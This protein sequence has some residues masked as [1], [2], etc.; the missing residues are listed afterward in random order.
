MPLGSTANYSTSTQPSPI[1]ESDILHSLL[2]NRTPE[3]TKQERADWLGW[4]SHFV[5]G[6]VMGTIAGC[7]C[8]PGKFQPTFV[9]ATEFPI[10]LSGLALLGGAIA[11]F[12]GDELWIGATYRVILP[13]PP[14]HSRRSRLTSLG[15]AIA[16]SLL[17]TIAL[18]RLVN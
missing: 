15:V 16:G 9:S 13:M 14:K 17:V 18:H 8:L 12:Y 7:L 3:E 4:S 11:S 2:M 1:S 10:F 5:A 6:S